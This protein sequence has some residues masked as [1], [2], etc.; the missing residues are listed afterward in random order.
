[1]DEGAETETVSEQ[2]KM[3]MCRKGGDG[4]KE[5]RV[6]TTHTQHIMLLNAAEEITV[7]CAPLWLF[8]LC[9]FTPP[10]LDLGGPRLISVRLKMFPV[11]CISSGVQMNELHGE[12][13][14]VRL[15]PRSPA[16]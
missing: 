2:E 15:L 4:I 11:A 1:M 14:S 16:L 3:Q 12:G 10:T 13:H 6:S 9:D 7:G 8:L 5:L